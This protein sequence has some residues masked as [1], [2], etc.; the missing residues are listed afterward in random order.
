MLLLILEHAQFTQYSD[1]FSNSNFA[2][3]YCS[4]LPS[5]K[6]G[7]FLDPIS[8][9]IFVA[10]LLIVLAGFDRLEG[11]WIIPAIIILMRELL[12]SGL[13][14]FLGPKNIQLPVSKLAKWKTT[15]QMF[16][17]GFLVVGD[18]GDIL[19]PNTL[20]YGQW[21]ILIAAMLTVITGWSYLTA[22]LKHIK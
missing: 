11:L 22:G 12:V 13:R 2:Y 8:D 20:T 9:K 4:P 5:C 21:G 15:V 10:S 14:E 6:L 7:K 1:F 19:L 17:L 16:A 18:H 3:H